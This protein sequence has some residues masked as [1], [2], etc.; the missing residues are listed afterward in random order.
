MSY[1]WRTKE[2]EIAQEPPGIRIP[3]TVMLLLAP[4]MGA[5]FVIFLP[6]VGFFVLLREVIRAVRRRLFQYWVGH[7]GGTGAPS[8]GQGGGR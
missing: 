2:W 4:V 8:K 7:T 3:V 5:L 6:M 1:Y